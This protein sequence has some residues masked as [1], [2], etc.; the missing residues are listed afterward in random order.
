M[1]AQPR[2]DEGVTLVELLVAMTIFTT[3]LAII[4]VAV[5][6]L[7]RSAVRSTSVA[8]TGQ[9]ARRAF[10]LLDKQ[11]RYADAVNFPGAAGGAHWVEFRTPPGTAVTTTTC[12]QWRYRPAAGRLETRSWVEGAT[13]PTMWSLVLVTASGTLQGQPFAML[14]T[15]TIHPLQRL[16]VDLTSRR[17]A[18]VGESV[19]KTTFVARNSSPASP[20]NIDAN[21]DLVSD[22]PV[23]SPSTNRS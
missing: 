22:I 4:M 17:Q 8:D 19:L 21:A 2:R 3:L 11:V 16:T 14:K 10:T 20:G 1:K 5:V 9:D 18:G 7:T 13:P 15:D 6:G 12:T 23:C